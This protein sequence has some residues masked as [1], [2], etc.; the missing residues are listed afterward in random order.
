MGQI[1]VD[2]YFRGLLGV[3][4]KCET[5]QIERNGAKRNQWKRNKSKQ[6]KIKPNEMELN[7]IKNQS[8]LHKSENTL[9]EM[10]F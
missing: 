6:N 3:P 2:K 5:K 7:N 10:K 9:I 1:F 4:I 8:C